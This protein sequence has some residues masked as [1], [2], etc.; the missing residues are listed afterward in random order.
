MGKLI[1]LKNMKNNMKSNILNEKIIGTLN[2]ILK[3]GASSKGDNFEDTVFTKL[4]G[5]IN[6]DK[7]VTHENWKE[8]GLYSK[9]RIR[10][11]TLNFDFSDLPDIIDN[12][13]LLN[14]LLIHNPNGTQKWPDI[15]IINNKKGFPIEIKSSKGDVIMWNGGLPRKNGLYI[16]NCYGP[17]IT[18]CFMGQ[19]IISDQQTLEMK[20]ASVS[21]SMNNTNSNDWE[22]YSRPMYNYKGKYVKDDEIMRNRENSSI[23]YIGSL[24][25]DNNQYTD[26]SK[27]C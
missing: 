13:Q 10:A 7:C 1:W 23:S 8:T 26:F 2:D 11:N 6:F 3:V 4:K 12:G 18:T 19:H 21:A 15:L 17:M 27:H 16:F 22:F 14:T 20:L 24:T 9:Y 25:W 5:N